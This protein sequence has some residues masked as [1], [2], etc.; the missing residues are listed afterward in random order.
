MRKYISIGL[1]IVIIIASIFVVKAMIASNKKPQRKAKKIVKTVFIDVVENKDIPITINANGNLVAKNKI[2]IF[3]EVQGV[4]QTTPKDFKPG[5]SYHK[6]EVILKINN[7]EHYANLQAQKSNLY[8]AITS[9]MP[10]IRLDYP[11]EYK[12]WQNYL[13]SFDFD[14][15]T[16]KLPEMNSEKEKFFISGRNIYTTYYNV[17]NME[18]RLN[19]YIIR[20]PYNGILTDAL[21]N[22]GSLVRQGQKLG[23]FINPSIY[24]MEVAINAN[25]IDLLKKGNKVKLQTLDNSKTWT[26]KVIRVN[27]KVD[28]TSQ[29]VKAFIQVDGKNLKEGMYLEANLVAKK[30]KNAYE[31]PRKLL[32]NN[33]SVFVL[34]DSVL[35]L[36]K[37]NAVYFKDKTVVIKGLE[38]GTK[39]LAKNVPG[40]YTGMA[41][42][43]FSE[44]TK[45]K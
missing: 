11:N 12:K 31:M 7:E 33:E 22:P 27:G 1:G 20:A 9:I 13:S 41:V 42:K 5:T 6:G 26:G 21:V 17:K 34:K 32:V 44:N 2:E 40:A 29:T 35:D 16:P 45:E 28:Q 4:L 3:S 36:V 8:N 14:K 24:E 39:V 15:T 30:E 23:E 19:K 18:V 43:V 37:V 10:D 38:N 25:Y